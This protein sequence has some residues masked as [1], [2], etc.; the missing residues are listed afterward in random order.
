[1]VFKL[2]AL[3][4]SRALLVGALC[5]GLLFPASSFG[6]EKGLETDMTWGTGSKVQDRTMVGVQDVGAGWVR[7]TMVWHDIETSPGSY[8]THQL[9]MYDS[10]IA[11]ARAGG[12]RVVVT[13]Y[14]APEWASGRTE[15]EAPPL[16]PADYARF[17]GAMAERYRGQVNAWEVWNEQ[18]LTRFWP[19][20]PDAAKYVALLKAAYPAFKSADASVPVVFGGMALN[21]YAYLEAAYRA[22]PDLGDYFDVMATHPYTFPAAPPEQGRLDANGRIDKSSFPAYREV[23]RTMLDHGDEK[24]IWFTEFGWST[25]TTHAGVSEQQQADYLTRAY[26]CIE[27]DPYV[28]VA[29]WFEYRNNYWAGDANTWE[30]QLGLIR[31]D[32]SQKP[33]YNSFK[34]YQP[35]TTGCTYTGITRTDAT[36]PPD[37]TPDPT[38]TTVP[39]TST[40][41]PVTSGEAESLTSLDGPFQVLLRVSRVGRVARSA[42]RGKARGRVSVKGR[43]LGAN[44]GRL[45]LRLERRRGHGRRAWRSAGSQRVR[46]DRHG[47]FSKR[48]KG[49]RRGSWRVRG[50]YAVRAGHRVRSRFAYFKV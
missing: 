36:P 48:L 32:F 15:R 30:D 18:N 28:Q 45:V 37:P 16:D 11:K 41:P 22:A 49:L 9:Q 12:A 14:G 43:V 7:L 13:V 4:W 26:R 38:P 34:N 31:T 1:M 10:A 5:V 35:G 2:S 20:R 3:R 44:G 47:A 6:A 19:S 46:I 24:P 23:R 21:D 27:Q 8:S 40:P 33:A 25:N 42:A 17:A 39:A 29:I 50:S